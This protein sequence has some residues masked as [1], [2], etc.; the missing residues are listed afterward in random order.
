MELLRDNFETAHMKNAYYTFESQCSRRVSYILATKNHADK[1]DEALSRLRMFKGAEDEL[2]VMDGG[3]TDHTKEIVGKYADIVDVFVSEPDQ[4]PAYANKSF[5]GEP[6]KD[7][8]NA[9]NK[10]ILLARGKYIK[11]IGDDDIYH[12]EGMEKAARILEEYPE[13]DLL[14]CGGTSERYGRIEYVYVSPGVNYGS[15]IEDVFLYGRGSGVGHFFKKSALAKVGMHPYYILRLGGEIVIIAD[16]EYVLKFFAN[17]C[18]VKFCRINLFHSPWSHYDCD[19]GF[20]SSYWFGAARRY[21]STAFY[22]KYFIKRKIKANFF[23]KKL[24]QFKKI[25]YRRT[26]NPILKKFFRKQPKLNYIWDGG[27]S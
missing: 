19:S 7:P 27:F 21:C 8:L 23:V 1:L 16:A 25:I 22:I 6:I 18:N 12:P 3:S 20:S 11:T 26:S 10:G 13:I 5:Y 14:M 4:H 2:L 9:V 17:G 24:K 15:S